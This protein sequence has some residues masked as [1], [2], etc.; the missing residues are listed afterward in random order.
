MPLFSKN[1]PEPVH[2]AGLK[3][4]RDEFRSLLAACKELTQELQWAKDF[5]EAKGHLNSAYLIHMYLIKDL[6]EE[7]IPAVRKSSEPLLQEFNDCRVSMDAHTK[8]LR[9]PC[10]DNGP[11]DREWW[12]CLELNLQHYAHLRILVNRL[13]KTISDWKYGEGWWES[14]GNEV[15]YHPPAAEVEGEPAKLRQDKQVHFDKK[16]HGW[17]YRVADAPL[18]MGKEEEEG[19]SGRKFVVKLAHD[20]FT[21]R[22]LQQKFQKKWRARRIKHAQVAR[23]VYG[24][25]NVDGSVY[26]VHDLNRRWSCPV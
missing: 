24:G 8:G 10:L 18:T 25:G 20:K 9:P 17:L 1:T 12:R 2:P 4:G 15:L 19:N 3:P 14:A 13:E 26:E 16:V 11:N 6:T 7:I 22:K 21:S 5:V 23:T